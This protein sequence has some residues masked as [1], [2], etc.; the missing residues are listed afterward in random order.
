MGPI[1]VN[2]QCTICGG[3]ALTSFPN[4]DPLPAV[5]CCWHCYGPRVIKTRH[6]PV[7]FVC[8]GLVSIYVYGKGARDTEPYDV[9]MK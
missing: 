2:N 1:T 4:Q 8:L 5:I 6:V 7:P 9:V 3:D